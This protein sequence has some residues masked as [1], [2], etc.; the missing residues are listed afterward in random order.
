MQNSSVHKTSI[1][2]SPSNYIVKLFSTSSN[3]L[4]ETEREGGIVMDPIDT[5]LV[6]TETLAVKFL[7]WYSKLQVYWQS[8]H[9]SGGEIK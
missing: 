5:I 6:S 8:E 3:Y 9:F 2:I 7:S 4:H 1:T